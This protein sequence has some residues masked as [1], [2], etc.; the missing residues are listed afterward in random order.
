MCV[1][2]TYLY[3]CLTGRNC[4]NLLLLYQCRL[5]RPFETPPIFRHSL[6]QVVQLKQQSRING[7][8]CQCTGEY[9][10]RSGR[11]VRRRHGVLALSCR[12][13]SVS[14]KGCLGTVHTADFSAGI[15]R[16]PHGIRIKSARIPCGKVCMKTARILR[17]KCA[18]C[19]DM[20]LIR[21]FSAW[22]KRGFAADFECRKR[23]KIRC[24]NSPLNV[25]YLSCTV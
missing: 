11:V 23:A 20:S 19:I 24:V 14:V 4:K 13:F 21:T 1:R 16:I 15:T 22:N 6:P 9:R 17:K 10:L 25:L 5:L 8:Q 2:T 7:R 18:E 3:G 12:V